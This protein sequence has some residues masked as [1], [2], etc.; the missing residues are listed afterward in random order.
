MPMSG[1]NFG[2]FHPHTLRNIKII[3]LVVEKYPCQ[4]KSLSGR[5]DFFRRFIEA[6]NA[7]NDD[8]NHMSLLRAIG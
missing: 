7:N 8:S 1:G 5:R 2:P 4:Q 6:I 3:R